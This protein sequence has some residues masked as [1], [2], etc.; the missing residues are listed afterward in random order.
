MIPNAVEFLYLILDLGLL[1]STDELHLTLPLIFRIIIVVSPI[2]VGLQ[3]IGGQV[4]L[5][6]VFKLVEIDE[7]FH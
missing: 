3:G 5:H 6:F 1:P 7:E 4:S 2:S